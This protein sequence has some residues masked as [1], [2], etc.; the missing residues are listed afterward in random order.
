MKA[1][2]LAAGV[3]SRLSPL[4]DETPKAL[5]K[6]GDRTL[7]EIVIRRVASAGI[8]S[9]VVNVHHFSGQIM[10]FLKANNNFGLDITISDESGELL[11]TGGAIRQAAPFLAGEEPVLV[12]N[13]DILSN[14]DI[15]AMIGFHRNQGA[16]VTMAVKDR[17]T[18]RSLLVDGNGRLCGWEYP[19]KKICIITRDNRKG[20]GATAFSGIYVFS[21]GLLAKLPDQRVF[22]LMPWL[23]D[24]AASEK[25]LTWDQG[26]A[27]WY[28]AGRIASLREAS[29]KLVFDDEDPAFI[30]EIS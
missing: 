21:P 23:L 28:E 6:V 9:A 25:I 22:G 5:L 11:D 15:P 12:H 17:P 24:L 29:S 2:I 27:F 13:I 7:L 26:A 18:T 30:R 16:L 14:L 8:Q 10:E 1:M 4:T 20:L 3:G 19:E